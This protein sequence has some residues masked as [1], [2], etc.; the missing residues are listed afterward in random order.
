MPKGNPQAA[1]RCSFCGKA[2]HKVRKLIAGPGGVYIC[3]ECVVLCQEIITEEQKPGIA[4]EVRLYN[5]AQLSPPRGFSH[6]AA[7]AGWVWLGGQIA[8]DADGNVLHPGD[9]AAQFDAAIRNVGIA[10]DAAGCTPDDV[11]KLMYFVTDVRAYRE[12]LKPIGASYRS[13]FGRHYPASTLIE[14]KGLFEPDA[15]I[16]IEGVAVRR[17]TTGDVKEDRDHAE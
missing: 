14:I 5:P 16:E 3:D 6:A 17:A 7:A 12:A 9:M 10:L 13:V 11:V 1:Y 8:S 4:S 2:Q 15:M